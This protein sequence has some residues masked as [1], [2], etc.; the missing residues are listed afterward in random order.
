VYCF[1]TITNFYYVKLIFL[2]FLVLLQNGSRRKY[3]L[4]CAFDRCYW[5]IA[6]YLIIFQFLLKNCN[7]LSLPKIAYIY[8][9]I[10]YERK[11]LASL[12]STAV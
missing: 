6:Q 1:A 2:A 4:Y 10:K 9:I 12:R 3:R 7:S 11:I 5:I 8:M